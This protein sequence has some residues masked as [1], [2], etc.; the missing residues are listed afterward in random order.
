MNH[1]WASNL[2]IDESIFKFQKVYIIDEG[3]PGFILEK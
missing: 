1:P 3:I 2:V